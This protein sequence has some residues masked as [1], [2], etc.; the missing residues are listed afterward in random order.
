MNKYDEPGYWF[1]EIRRAREKRDRF[2]AQQEWE[3][4]VEIWDSGAVSVT[5]E[6]QNDKQQAKEMS[7]STFVNWVWAFGQTFIP[8]VYWKQPHI[9]AHAKKPMYEASVPVVEA[10]INAAFELTKFR[11]AVRRAMQDMLAYGHG[12]VKLGWHTKFGQVPA[13]PMALDDQARAL[14]KPSLLDTEINLIFDEPYA[15]RVSPERIFLDPEASCYEEI[16]WIAQM[17]YVSYEAIKKDPYLKHTKDIT[18]MAYG[19]SEREA[20]LPIEKG[21]DWQDKENRWC[22][23]YEVWDRERGRVFVMLQGAAKFNR[24]M[25]WPY[26]DIY[27][28]PFKLL[29]VTESIKDIYPVSTMLPWLS[30]VDELA[31]LRSMRMDHI[32]RMTNKCLVPPNVLDEDSLQAMTDPMQDIVMCQ[33]DPKL[34]ETY[35]GLQPDANLYASE[36]KVKEDIRE[37]SGY[38]EILSGQV[39]FS[40]IAATTSAIMERNATIRF[41][42][43]S[44]LVAE[45]IIDCAKDLFKI[46][47]RFQSF[48]QYVKVTGSPQAEWTE[49]ER[50][51][52]DG[53]YWFK[54]DLE[55]MS[56]SSK[57]QRIKEAYDALSAL[58]PFPQHVKT[59]ALIRDF[60]LAMGKGDL[61]QYMPPPAGSPLDPMFE[62]QMMARGLPVEPNPNEDFQ[63]HLMVHAQFVES[64]GYAQLV[65]QVP[66]IG[67]LFSEHIQKTNAMAGMQQQLGPPVGQGPQSQRVA[68]N[69]SMQQG[70]ALAGSS[71]P[72]RPT[73]AGQG[74]GMQ[75]MN[76]ALGMT[77]RG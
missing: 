40:R 28:F 57:Q 6:M 62:N 54:L 11:K 30:L 3:K 16:S 5:L 26:P 56:V 44:E 73:N 47:R 32:Q 37:I 19:D 24:E 1:K 36:D 71:A 64:P 31:F 29:S 23:M 49:I 65:A 69:Q 39:P 67:A 43:Y 25:P 63:L 27:G 17:S 7:Q 52:L 18:P 34:I 68:A 8:A 9:N 15:Y 50:D 33:G 58:A 2:S 46:V 51:V 70:R 22:R 41:D 4:L 75:A 13:A 14:Q 60:L 74:A 66:Q 77:G 61:N 10:V 76:K 20:F 42:F 53:D 48:P 38:S 72:V 12:W 21:N 45:F 55:E 59:E 35:K